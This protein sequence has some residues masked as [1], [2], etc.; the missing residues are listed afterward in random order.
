MKKPPPKT[1]AH[2]LRLRARSPDEPGAP[3]A[4]SVA[5]RA[6]WARCDLGLVYGLPPDEE[7]VSLANAFVEDLPPSANP[8]LS[9]LACLLA[10]HFRRCV[11]VPDWRYFDVAFFASAHVTANFGGDDG[12]VD[13][14][15][16]GLAHFFEWLTL[17]GV[18]DP[19]DLLSLRLNT[20]AARH[21]TDVDGC[22]LYGNAVTPGSRADESAA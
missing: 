11:P 18:V 2:P 7:D 17:V 3:E 8:L 4:R 12:E 16:M 1:L 5:E 14:L 15:L 10:L 13:E 19:R 9:S 20:E 22:R 6:W 21:P